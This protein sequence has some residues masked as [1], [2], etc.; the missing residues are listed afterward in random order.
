VRSAWS[1]VVRVCREVAHGIDAVNAVRHGRRPSV[2]P[3]L[4]PS[5][6]GVPVRPPVPGPP[7]GRAVRPHEGPDGPSG[8]YEPRAGTGR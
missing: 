7:P 3:Y 8:P 1:A 4:P 6:F 5:L 2:P